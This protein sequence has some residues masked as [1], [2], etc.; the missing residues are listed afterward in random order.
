MRILDVGAGYGGCSV[1]LI[2]LGAKVV[3]IDV[4]PEAK[5]LAEIYSRDIASLTYHVVPVDSPEFLEFVSEQSID[6]IIMTSVIEHVQDIDNLLLN[7]IKVL[8]REGV[9][10]TVMPNG[11]NPKIISREPHCGSFGLS[12][13]PPQVW[14][15][16]ARNIPFVYYRTFDQYESIFER[17]G[18]DEMFLLPSDNSMHSV[19][20]IL[21]DAERMIGEGLQGWLN[22]IEHRGSDSDVALMRQ[23]IKSH[24]NKMKYNSDI[25]SVL[26][27][28]MNYGLD[29]WWAFYKL[30]STG[31]EVRIN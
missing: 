21:S 18:F 15:R 5:R 31:A 16:F 7:C 26:K 10:F 11:L 14:Y 3:S 27:F 19:D 28:N 4:D 17:Y 29:T 20:F 25:S 9:L 13:L 8:D 2:K 24:I 12:I 6:V 23:C 22:S 1:E 30:R